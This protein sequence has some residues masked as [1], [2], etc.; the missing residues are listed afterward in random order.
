MKTNRIVKM[1]T[2][3]M[4][5]ALVCIA[6]SIII[7]PLPNGF[8]N[9]GDCFVMLA[10]GLLGPIWGTLAAA[11]G[12]ALADVFLGYTVYA[13]ATFIIKGCVALITA[14]LW[15]RLKMP[16]LPRV[17]LSTIPAALCM[18]GGY[19]V[20]ELMLYGPAATATL[21]GNTIQGSIGAVSA[22]VLLPLLQKL[23]LG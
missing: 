2:A 19:F 10:G 5:C 14:L 16:V 22:C 6:T 7:I 4:F 20:F 12:S 3:A 15:R 11:L 8:A 17:L 13:P 9:L 18:V 1:V 21:V 23:K